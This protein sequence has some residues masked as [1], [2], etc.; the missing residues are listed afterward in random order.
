MADAAVRSTASGGGTTGG[1]G[2]P[3]VPPVADNRSVFVKLRDFYN[4]VMVEMRKVT[5]PDVP[6]VRS[7]T[8]SI[9]IFVLLLGLFITLLDFVLQG[10]LIKLI[11]SLFAGR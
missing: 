7:A 2:R 11:P 4:G 5:W 1:S 9:I 6:Q 8:I 10:V 3:P